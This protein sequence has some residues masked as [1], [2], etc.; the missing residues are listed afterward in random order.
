M[1]LIIVALVLVSLMSAC[2]TEKKAI[3]A[4]NGGKYQN[5]IDLFKKTLSS[6]PDN[7]KA[8]YFVAESFRL[9]NRIKEAEP[10]YAKAGGRGI[11]K[12][13]IQFYY[14]QALKANTKYNEAK[15]QLE[16]L[17]A[18]TTNVALK[19]RANAEIKGLQY[20]AELDQKKNFYR[21]KNLEQ[22][23]S[24]ASEY[25][26]VFLNNELYFTSSR[27][28]EKIYEATGTPYTDIFKVA[29]RGANVDVATLTPLQGINTQS[30]NDG[31]ITFSPDGKTMIFAKGNTGKRKGTNATE[32]VDLFIS[33]FRNNTWSE[34]TAIA[35]L[36]DVTSWDSSPTFSPDGK[37]LYFA[38]NRKGR[39][40]AI[41][42]YGGTDIYSAV[43]DSRG[44]FSRVRN[45]GPQ[46]N[47][48]GNELFPY[49]AEDGKLYF[50]SDGHP[51]YGGLDLFVVK[52]LN[53]RTVI[54]NLGQ[55]MNS[56]SDDFGIFL[57]KPDRGFYTSNRDGGK[58][59]DDIYTFVNEDPDL[60]VINYYLQ[61][62]TY[63]PSGDDS[64]LVVLPNTKVSL[65][66][67]R[68]EL[69]QDY[70]TGNDGKFLF[71]VYENENYNL[72][73]ETDGYLV[74]RQLFSTQGKS[75]DPS[76][77]KDLINNIT[78]D[79]TIVLDKIELNKIFVLENIY[80]NFNKADIREDAA[81]ELDKL[82]QLLTDNPEIKIELGSH[83]DSVDTDS[84][85]IDL[86]QRRADA[87][88]RYI[89]QHGIAPDR[90]IAKGYGESKPIGRNTNPDGSDNPA[91][92]QK[93]RRTE[94]KILEIGVIPKTI[95]DE[96]EQYDEDKYFRGSD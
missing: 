63:T 60:K 51:G 23:N 37:T 22:L 35:G 34:P 96:E 83:T 27:G 4:F 15:K 56:P 77:L 61:G 31:C 66:D 25:S 74:K 52:R 85:N 20:L 92:R 29:S 53:G 73:A 11:D 2:S 50:S 62:V 3:K 9:S 89:V 21:I 8:N 24:P 45:M 59:D 71:R 78:L 17:G 33:R 94:F 82:V 10:F 41:A 12:D 91:G 88:V 14:A 1:R 26:P 5:S 79:T 86:S 87:A 68:G 90:L 32:D 80:Y 81:I 18:R 42:G 13:S 64:T 7:A 44:R 55:P 75:V 6:N 43:M 93:N 95:E 16:E 28:N 72:V 70:L 84:Y 19:D 30:I 76:T 38:S 36:N 40:K 49:V 67:E 65:V 69:M 46:V 58:G 48:P 54:E 57:F 39:G 47:T